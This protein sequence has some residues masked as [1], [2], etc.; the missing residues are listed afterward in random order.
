MSYTSHKHH[1]KHSTF[2]QNYEEQRILGAPRAEMIEREYYLQP[3][4]T[5]ENYQVKED[6][7]READDFIKLEHKKFARWETSMSM[8]SG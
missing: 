1:A 6:V 8:K 3:V 2:N 5:T 7:N 4:G